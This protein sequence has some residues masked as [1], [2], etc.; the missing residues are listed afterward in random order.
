M[1]R[2]DGLVLR[3]K[4]WYLD[5]RIDGKRYV[6]RLGKNISRSVAGE[7]AS[8]K[9]AAFLKGEVGIRK[10]RD[11]SF[12]DAREKFEQWAEANKKPNTLTTYRECLRRLAESFGGTRLSMI[13]PFAVEAHKQ[14]RL[15]ARARVRANRECAVLKA[16]FHRCQDWGLFEGDNPVRMVKFVKEPRQRLRYLEPEEEHRLL[17]AAPEPLRSI[18]LVGIHCG[19]RLQAEALT[20]KWSDVDLSRRT[21][22]V[23]AGYAK[24]GQTRTVPLNSAVLVALSRL[25]AEANG[26]FVFTTR[27]GK[28]YD[29]I[30]NG[31]ESACTRAGL[32]GVTPHTTRHSFA[33]RLIAS[34]VDLRTVQELGGWSSLRMLERYGHVSPA[35]K[36]QAVEGL[37]EAFHNGI[38]NSGDTT[39]TTKPLT[40][41]KQRHG[42]VAEWPKA[43]VC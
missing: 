13:S 15:Q 3:G 1:R 34:G 21:L 32:E 41:R 8:V 5:A 35:R 10:K 36:V 23:Q 14:R 17:Q 24:S 42:E 33:T 38:H 18:I 12:K 30:R 28:P 40:L 39:R 2:G 25:K 27:T 7:L 43:T 22:T 20:L 16:L 9:R 26:E 31:I 6:A 37:V 4:S 29:S 11:L 19:L